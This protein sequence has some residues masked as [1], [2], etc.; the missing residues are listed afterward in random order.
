VGIQAPKEHETHFAIQKLNNSKALGIDDIP[1]EL[2][3]HG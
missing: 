2:L 3:S 1:A